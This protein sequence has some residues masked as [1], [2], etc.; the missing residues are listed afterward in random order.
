MGSRL[1]DR[2]GVYYQ[3]DQPSCFAWSR[4]VSQDLG[5]SLLKLGNSLINWDGLVTLFTTLFPCG[6]HC[7]AQ[8]QDTQSLAESR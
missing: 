2:V 4:G 6:C 8:I 1:S 5:L 7:C 3:R